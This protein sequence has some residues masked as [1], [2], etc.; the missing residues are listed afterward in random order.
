L[1]VLRADVTEDDRLWDSIDEDPDL[2]WVMTST[3]GFTLKEN[4]VYKI[5]FEVYPA[6]IVK[7]LKF[8]GP[9]VNVVGKNAFV[10]TFV[11]SSQD[12]LNCFTDNPTTEI[13]VR[14]RMSTEQTTLWIEP[15]F[16]TNSLRMDLRKD[17][18]ESKLRQLPTDI[19]LVLSEEHGVTISAHSFVLD[20]SS[21][22]FKK[23]RDFN[24]SGTIYL[25]DKF[26]KAIWDQAVEYMY[27]PFLETDCIPNIQELMKL[28]DE[29]A[30]ESLVRDGAIRLRTLVNDN[31]MVDALSYV[32]SILSLVTFLIARYTDNTERELVELIKA[33][34]HLIY[35]KAE[36]VMQ[37]HSFLIAFAE[38]VP[39][40]IEVGGVIVN[41][42]TEEFQSRP[43]TI[44]GKRKWDY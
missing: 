42:T 17:T 13:V 10:Q 34:M 39:S 30:I 43:L 41:R 21:T 25:D 12:K 11:K 23:A 26:S 37:D 32:I 3:R 15:L 8:V 31:I 27:N 24:K 29:Y 28:A 5:V 7:D 1:S 33:C 2:P 18:L 44:L 22:F 19:S 38:V 16:Q 40:L 4:R 20:S 6:C 14:T 36:C 35:S 9:V